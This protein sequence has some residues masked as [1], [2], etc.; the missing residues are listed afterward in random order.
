[1]LIHN[2]G[3]F[4]RRQFVHWGYPG[5]LGH[6][7]GVRAVS[8]EPV[9]FRFQQGVYCLYNESFSLVYVG[10][11]GGGRS[12]RLFDRLKQHR[13]DSLAERWSKF[14]W[15]GV[16]EISEDGG[17]L[18]SEME[19]ASIPINLILNHIEA[20]L[21]AAAE[22]VQN[23]QRGRFGKEVVHYRQYRDL[24]NIYPESEKMIQDI[25]SSLPE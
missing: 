18:S 7:K 1:M 12:Q 5:N 2:Y 19:E 15:F 17:E 4:W 13:D 24:E 21:I 6:L 14:S 3:L 16:R 11:A 8:E 23:L 10:Q 22:P 25:W 9:D 20:I